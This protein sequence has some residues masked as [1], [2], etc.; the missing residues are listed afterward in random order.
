MRVALVHDWLTGLRGG[1]K[2]LAAFLELY[3]NA[4]VYTLIHKKGSTLDTIDQAVVGTSFLNMLPAVEKYYR[5]LLPLFPMAVNSIKLEGYDLVISTSHAAV[6]NIKLPE[7]TMHVSYCFTPMRYIWDQ[8][9]TY[10]GKKAY[11]SAPIIKALRNWD[12][13][14][15]SGV[16][17]FI[18][19]SKLVAARIRAYYGRRSKVIYPP[20]DTSWISPL[21]NWKRGDAFLYAGA[22][23]PY[24]R[25]DL[26]VEA[27]NILKLPLVVAG[28]GPEREKLE[29]IAKDNIHFLG[30][31]S[32]ADLAELYRNCRAL[33]FPGKEDFGM[34]PVEAQAA[35]RPV[36]ALE[37][38]GAR[39]TILGYTIGSNNE[40]TSKP[41]SGVFFKA[42]KDMTEELIDAVKFFIKNEEL[43]TIEN[44]VNQGMKFSP[45]LFAN[46]WGKFIA[47]QG[48]SAPEIPQK[49]MASNTSKKAFNA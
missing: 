14:G 15:S 49:W 16:D 4:D 40:L 9:Q 24:K 30:R 35:G 28:S 47:Q 39:E 26:I 13:N 41:Y 6:K 3:P 11:F 45:L 33:I 42:S 34:V 29:K 19:I 37:S 43:F 31:V 17:E 36:I 38:G 5:Y 1:E 44:C 8:S 18:A 12:K 20:V 48:F 27:F 23:V 10:L 46:S 2:C 7:D 32:D 25:V 22:L 21:T